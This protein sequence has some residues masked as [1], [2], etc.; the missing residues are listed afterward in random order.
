MNWALP[1]GRAGGYTEQ[2]AFLKSR[3]RLYSG[4]LYF[5]PGLGPYQPDIHPLMIWWAVLYSLS[6]L[7]RYHPAEW[8]AH[9]DVDRSKYAVPL[10]NLLTQAMETV[11]RL[12]IEVIGQLAASAPD[13]GK[14]GY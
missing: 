5:F 13:D 4:S 3:T 9:I 11:P 10:E 6:M 7:A 12:I 8:A 2:M 1:S 14:V